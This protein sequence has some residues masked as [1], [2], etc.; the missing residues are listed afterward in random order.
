MAK[1]IASKTKGSKRVD[2]YWNSEYKE[3]ALVFWKDGKMLVDADYF[4][5][6]KKDAEGT[7]L[8]FLSGE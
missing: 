6:D 1:K 5:S 3:Y 7:V 8:N 2:T 4:T